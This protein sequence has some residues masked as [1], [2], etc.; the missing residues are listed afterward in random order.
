LH[1]HQFVDSSTLIATYQSLT[2][3][4]T[5][6]AQRLSR[7]PIGGRCPHCVGDAGDDRAVELP[8]LPVQRHVEMDI[9][10]P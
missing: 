7:A 3:M 8:A 9:G 6:V 4:I 5:R 1:I 10:D 2:L